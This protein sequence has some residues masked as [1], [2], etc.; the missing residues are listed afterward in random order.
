ML[1]QC[2]YARIRSLDR[3]SLGLWLPSLQ[4]EPVWL[5]FGS[6]VQIQSQRLTMLPCGLFFSPLLPTTHLYAP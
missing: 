5:M 1:V 2:N 6:M 3:G 4:L